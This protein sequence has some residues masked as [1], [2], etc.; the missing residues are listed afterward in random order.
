MTNV[1]NHVVLA[2]PGSLTVSTSS[3]SAPGNFG[4]VSKVGNSPRD[5]QA[6]LRINW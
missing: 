6:A 4:V 5:V 3:A 2:G 1:T